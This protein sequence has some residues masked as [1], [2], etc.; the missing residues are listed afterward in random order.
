MQVPEG[1]IKWVEAFR[2]IENLMPIEEPADKTKIFRTLLK[3]QALS[4]FELHL[5][6]RLEAEDSD[7][8]GNELIELVLRDVVLEYIPKR[9][10]CVQ[11]YYMM[12]PRSLYMGLNISLQQFV[13]RLHE[14]SCYLLYVPEENPKQLDQDEIIE[15]LDQAKAPEWHEAMV[16]EKIDIF[17]MSHE[18]SV[19]Y[20]KRLENLEKIRRTNGPNPSSLPVYDKK[21]ISVTS[22]VVKSS[23]NHKGSNM[24][25]HYCDKSNHNMADFI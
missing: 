15:I 21:E 6:K 7:I 23:K 24:W 3:G 1:W 13:E 10:I 16:N 5:M 18:E 22:S 9:T 8:P 20:F 2:E 14:L 19:S 17:E 11:K 25:C 12:H 4:Y